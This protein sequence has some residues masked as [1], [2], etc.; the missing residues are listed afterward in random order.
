ML[1]YQLRN[2]WHVQSYERH[3]QKYI[4]QLKDMNLQNRGIMESMWLATIDQ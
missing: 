1:Y 2:V 4:M 3:A